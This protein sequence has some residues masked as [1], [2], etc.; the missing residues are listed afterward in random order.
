MLRE[1]AEDSMLAE[2]EHHILL[3]VRHIPVVVEEVGFHVVDNLGEDFGVEDVLGNHMELGVVGI[4]LVE[5]GILLVVGT[6]L[7]VDPSLAEGG[8]HLAGGSH[9]LDREVDC[10]PFD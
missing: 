9:R 7:V 4:Q 5:E 2:E 8:N 10:M 1:Q 6:E 3:V